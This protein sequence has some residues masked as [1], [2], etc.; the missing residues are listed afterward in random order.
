MTLTAIFGEGNEANQRR[1]WTY[2]F[3]ILG[4]DY[5]E[6]EITIPSQ[7][8]MQWQLKLANTSAQNADDARL[9]IQDELALKANH[10]YDADETPKSLKQVED[11]K[12][13]EI[14]QLELENDQLPYNI[15][16][17]NRNYQ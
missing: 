4:I 12:A 1:K 7:K 5:F 16:E 11:E 2:L 17:K 15:Y 6:G 8:V 3:P 14:A 10:G 13:G 9:A